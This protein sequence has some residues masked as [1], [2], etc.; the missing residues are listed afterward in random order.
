MRQD[1]CEP[2]VF[3]GGDKYIGLLAILVKSMAW[4]KGFSKMIHSYD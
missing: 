4:A 2:L 1:E 3:H